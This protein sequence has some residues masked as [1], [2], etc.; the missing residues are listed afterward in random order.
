MSDTIAPTPRRILVI[1]SFGQL[2]SELVPELVRR[3]GAGNVLA[4]D[5]KV[6]PLEYATEQLDVMDKNRVMQFMRSYK[7]DVVY[8]LAAVLSATGEKLP[9]MAWDVNIQGLFHVLD[10]ARA[11]QVKQI[12]WPSSM[13]V[14]GPHTPQEDTP[15]YC[16]MDPITVYGITKLT[17]EL[18]AQ[19]YH[20]RWGMDIRSLRYPGLISYKTPPTGGT[21]DYAVYMLQAAAKGQNYTSYIDA[22]TALPMMYMPDAIKATLNLMDA[23]A[24]RIGIRTSYNLGAFSLTPA[25][26]AESIRKHLPD[27]QVSYQPDFR[28]EIAE[29]WPNS[30]DDSAAR[31]D[32]GWQPDYDLDAMVRHMLVQYGAKLPAVV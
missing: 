17:G 16:M 10:T 23:P 15:Q 9:A 27:F 6:R 30:L 13:A 21:T 18:L 19:Y 7:F 22:H 24:E 26:L 2:G 5:L 14:F 1:G 25:Q 31:Q 32:W 11:N 12:F 28:Q 3:Y 4:T 8:H 20:L 29:S